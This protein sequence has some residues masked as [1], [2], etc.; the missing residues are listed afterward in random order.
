METLK[1]LGSVS[2]GVLR[3]ARC[4][5]A[6]VPARPREQDTSSGRSTTP[7]TG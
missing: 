1:D 5:V 6:V 2:R 7:R 3:Y 4:P